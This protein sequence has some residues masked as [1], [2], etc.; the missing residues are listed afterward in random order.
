MGDCGTFDDGFHVPQTPSKEDNVS[1][2]KTLE[3]PHL[4]KDTQ[5][6][7]QSDAASILCDVL[8]E[9]NASNFLASIGTQMDCIIGRKTKKNG[10]EIAGTISESTTMR[11]YA[12]GAVDRA[13]EAKRKRK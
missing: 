8:L 7:I 9:K 3:R 2:S 6:K 13:S 5:K 4:Q 1:S 12:V 11:E 10:E